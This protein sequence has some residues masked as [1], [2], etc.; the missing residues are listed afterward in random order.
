[1]SYKAGIVEAIKEL[2]DRNGSSAIA[3]KKV[4]QGKLAKDK[5]WQNATFLQ[6]L[7]NGVAAGEFV[8]NK[9]SYKLSADFKKKA[10]KP[11]KAAPA[12]KAKAP[13]TKKKAPVKKT[14][15]KKTATKK[16]TKPKKETTTKK[17]SYSYW[18]TRIPICESAASPLSFSYSSGSCQEE[19]R[20][21]EEGTLFEGVCRRLTTS[22]VCCLTWLV[23]ALHFLCS[24]PPPRRRQPR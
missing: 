12:K 3:I 6:A 5:K 14:T 2:K 21:Q 23:C 8:Q 1:M 4:M 24:R 11:K 15:A 18:L 7:K 17:V 9:N 16:T 10:A 20:Y 19:D 22:S 13:V